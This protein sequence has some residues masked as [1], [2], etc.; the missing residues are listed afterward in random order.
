MPVSAIFVSKMSAI[1]FTLAL[2]S[3]SVAFR[4]DV[5][6]MEGEERHAEDLEHLKGDIG[7]ERACAIGSP[8]AAIQVR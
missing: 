5:A 6:V 1:A 2:L 3:A 8:P 7:F 4:R